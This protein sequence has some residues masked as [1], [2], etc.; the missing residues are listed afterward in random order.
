MAP[1]QPG[2]KLATG[3]K[4]A[5][6]RISTTLLNE[7]AADFE[8]H[9]AEVVKIARIE[10]PVEYLKVI[11]SLLPKEF[12]ITATTKIREISDDELDHLIN[13]AE[14]RLQSGARPTQVR[15]SPPYPR[16]SY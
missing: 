4:N 3:R 1:F 14:R 16:Q 15:F 11:A 12:E 10:R 6:H 8:Q 13:L 9:G 7:L 2:N 5:R